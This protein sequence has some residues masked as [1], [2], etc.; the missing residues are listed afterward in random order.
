MTMKGLTF[1]SLIVGGGRAVTLTP[2][3]ADKKIA[4]A[5]VEALRSDWKAIG[6]DM[7]QAMKR[8]HGQAQPR[9]SETR[10]DKLLTG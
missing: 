4:G 9:P 3:S 8:F 1:R 5:D 2:G 10:K 7:S 6:R